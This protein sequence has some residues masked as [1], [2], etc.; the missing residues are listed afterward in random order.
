MTDAKHD[1]HL[2]YEHPPANQ[3]PHVGEPDPGADLLL[4]FRVADFFLVRSPVLPLQRFADWAEC[5]APA[6]ALDALEPEARWASRCKALRSA[7]R[8][9]F[10]D[11]SL[12]DALYFASPA[13]EQLIGEQAAAALAPKFARTLTRYFARA[14][15]RETPFGLFASVSFGSVSEDV[16]LE[17]AAGDRYRRH[18]SVAMSYLHQ[19]LDE[20]AARED[21]RDSVPREL[22]STLT[23]STDTFRFATRESSRSLGS[24]L[25][26]VD[27]S[28]ELERVVGR[29]G[30]GATPEQLARALTRGREALHVYRWKI[31][32]EG[33]ALATR[34]V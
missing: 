7:L 5:G 11:S 22:N 32:P 8:K 4:Q 2:V 10:D 12:R 26:E 20:L 31:Q 30:G 18:T 25:I 33:A 13:L 34:A 29:A 23:R 14:A 15:A 17:F 1:E 28:A 19:I 6:G 21:V 3:K 16:C 27:A 9:I 24:S